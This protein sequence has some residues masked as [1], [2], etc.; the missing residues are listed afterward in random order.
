MPMPE[1]TPMHS[2]ALVE[3][4]GSGEVNPMP[5][6]ETAPMPSKVLVEPEGSGEV[7]PMPLP[8]TATKRLG[9]VFPER[10]YVCEGFGK[11]FVHDLER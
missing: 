5:L 10:I 6:P 1:T 9:K 7:N 2:K 4:E 8:E 3:L 11:A